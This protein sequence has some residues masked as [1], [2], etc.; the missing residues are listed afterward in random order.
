[1]LLRTAIAVGTRISL[2][3]ELFATPQATW[4]TDI[5][6]LQSRT[7]ARISDKRRQNVDRDDGLLKRES[8]L[9]IR[10]SGKIGK[11]DL[12]LWHPVLLEMLA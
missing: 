9:Q 1:M 2:T 8:I 10:L 5:L 7:F 6:C 12:A 11:V 4:Q 3:G